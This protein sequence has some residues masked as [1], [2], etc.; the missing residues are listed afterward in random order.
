MCERVDVFASIVVYEPETGLCSLK[1]GGIVSVRLSLSTCDENRTPLSFSRHAQINPLPTATFSIF[2]GNGVIGTFASE[3]D[4]F[5]MQ[6]HNDDD[7]QPSDGLTIPA[8][9]IP[10]PTAS[11]HASSVRVL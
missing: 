3:R 5:K 9:S 10:D 6:E 1:A 8:E 11:D 7:A 4:I 2:K